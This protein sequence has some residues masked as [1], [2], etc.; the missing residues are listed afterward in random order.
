MRI[1]V[2][3]D[4][5]LVEECYPGIGKPKQDVIA[6]VKKQKQYGHLIV[7]YTIR[8][9]ILLVKAITWCCDNGIDFD[10]VVIIKPHAEVYLD[11]KS[12]KISDIKLIDDIKD[13]KRGQ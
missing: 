7:L 12:M 1:A 3:F 11:D 5:T 6:W 4:G 13:F 10:E 2:D 9:G 8:K